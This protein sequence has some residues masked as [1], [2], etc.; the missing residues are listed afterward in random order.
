MARIVTG[1][2]FEPSLMGTDGPMSQQDSGPYNCDTDHGLASTR[3]KHRVRSCD[4]V[5][6]CRSGDLP[7][8]EGLALR[9]AMAGQG[10]NDQFPYS[11]DKHGKQM[12]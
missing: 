6:S 4:E 11:T 12:S 10:E 7:L 3:S 2:G 8:S 5:A 1:S 9:Q